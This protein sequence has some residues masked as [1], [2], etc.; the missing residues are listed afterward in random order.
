MM[1]NWANTCPICSETIQDGGVN[2]QAKGLA[3]LIDCSRLRGDEKLTEI[4]ENCNEID[5]KVKLRVHEECR[6]RYTNQNLI[7]TVVKNRELTDIGPSPKKLRRDSADFNWFRDCFFCGEPAYFDDRNFKR[8]PVYRVRTLDFRETIINECQKR[9]DSKSRSL[10]T[11]VESCLCLVAAE[12]RYHHRCNRAFIS[13]RD[14][15]LPGRPVN[16]EKHEWFTGMCEWLEDY[17]SAELYTISELLQKMTDLAAGSEVYGEKMLREKL[18]QRYGEHIFF[19]KVG[20]GQP[21][22]VCFRDMAG[23]IINKEWYSNRRSDRKAELERLMTTCARLIK[24]EIRER[25]YNKSFYPSIDDIRLSGENNDFLTPCLQTLLNHLI[26]NDIKRNFIG[27]MIT[28]GARPRSVIPPLMFGLGVEVDLVFGSQWLLEELSSFGASI[29]YD[30]V[31]LFKQ[32]LLMSEKTANLIPPNPTFTQWSADNAD[33]TID[34]LTGSGQ[35]H[36]IGMCSMSAVATLP[37]GK[38]QIQRQTR[39]KV[40]ALIGDAD[41][42]KVKHIR[43]AMTALSPIKFEPIMNLM[44]PHIIPAPSFYSNLMWQSARAFGGDKP[45]PN[46][47]GYME[48]FHKDHEA[49]KW[50][51]HILP[52]MDLNPTEESNIYTCLKFIEDQ[53]RTLEIPCIA[54]TFDQSLWLKATAIVESEKMTKFVIRL[55]GF[56]LLMS[57]LG[58]ACGLMKGSG[59]EESLE[60]V[61]GENVV[62]HIMS[63]KAYARSV[64]ANLLVESALMTL[65][66][67]ALMPLPSTSQ[68]SN[69][70]GDEGTDDEEYIDVDQCRLSSD[71]VNEIQSLLALVL[72]ESSGHS[73]EEVEGIVNSDAILKLDTCLRDLEAN[74]SA[75]SRVAKLWLQHRD[76]IGR[77]KE[78]IRC[79]RMCD[80]EGHLNAVVN[81]LNLFAA[82]NH[83]HYAKSA[84]LYVQKMRKLPETHPWLYA[85]FATDGLHAVRR[86]AKFWGGLSTDLIIEQVVMRRLK[87]R[88]GLTHGRGLSESVRWQWVH[89]MDHCSAVLDAVASVTNRRRD[90]T[91]QHADLG[92]TRLAKDAEHSEALLNWYSNHNPFLINCPTLRSIAT[93]LTAAPSHNINCDDAETI[94]AKIHAQMTGSDITEATIKKKDCARTLDQ[95]NNA[96][97]INNKTVQIDPLVLFIRCATLAER[98]DDDIVS[99]FEYEMAPIP[100]SLFK[101]GFMRKGNKADMANALQEKLTQTGVNEC[102]RSAITVIDGGWLVHQLK[103]KRD[104]SFN[105]V[106]EQYEKFISSSYGRLCTVVFDGYSTSSTKDHEHQRRSNGKE[107]A[108]IAFR[109]TDKIPPNVPAF[110]ANSKNKSMFVK[111]LAECLRNHGHSVI[112]C[113]D[114]A[115][116]TIVKTAIR[117]ASE[118]QSVVIVAEDTDIFIMLLHH[119][120]PDHAEIYLRKENRS[121]RKKAQVYAMSHAHASIEENIRRNILFLHAWSGCDTTSM[122]FGHGKTS[123]LKAISTSQTLQSNASI[124][125]SD[126]ADQTAVG[127]AGVRIFIELCGYSNS[128]GDDESSLPALRYRKYMA[129]MAKNKKVEPERLP[130]TP[131]ASHFHSLRVH[132]QVLQWKCLDNQR[133]DPLQWGW[134]RGEDQSLTPIMTDMHPAPDNVLKFVRCNCKSTKNQCNTNVC[135]CKKHFVKC[136][137]ACGGCHGQTCGNTETYSMEIQD[138]DGDD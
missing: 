36:G 63:G 128:S 106:S 51:V 91:H 5:G 73:S 103:W 58:A 17:G 113:M 97:K 74:L 38:F 92:K 114:D 126:D 24:E 65:L 82:A 50:S 111:L 9:G 49:D 31:R 130:P 123:I 90:G 119:W 41:L 25:D 43:S 53:A 129:M 52:F 67:S 124:I 48:H 118:N 134:R 11:R 46:W 89:T 110:L 77:I 47:S 132:L 40:S 22:V 15:S 8:D 7:R 33:C 54:V 3:T 93:G 60:V 80:W 13:P 104:T 136:V 37:V 68:P 96:I 71:D 29:S 98:M 66:I 76:N 42:L 55:G 44:R 95:V 61:Y 138:S 116:T 109:P 122:T 72:E 100:P 39:V 105:D 131:R 28:A 79:E 56:H 94:G 30:E 112:E 107:S 70:D 1:N 21:D 88:G 18:K 83:L 85:R 121:S 34:T 64:R 35:F 4:F 23:Y 84:R 102:P 57:A 16:E 99:Y 2:V 115:D 133:L 62:S 117:Y 135:S 81:L 137:P 59:L 32:S 20:G 75:K 27:Q 12:A 78:F 19:A 10:R 101:D 6:K 69:V 120:Q 45:S 86:S 87:S 14:N 125:A 108:D 127:K 26:A